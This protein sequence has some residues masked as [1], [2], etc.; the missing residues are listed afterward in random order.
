MEVKLHVFLT[1]ALDGFKWLASRPGQF[2]PKEWA[3]VRKPVPTATEWMTLKWLLKKNL[4]K[5]QIAITE[6]I[7][8]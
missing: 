3:L 4:E 1:S 5:C 8:I 7:P 2:N 6:G